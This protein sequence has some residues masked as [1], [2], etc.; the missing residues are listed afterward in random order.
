M[1]R[2]ETWSF[3]GQ[4]NP[5][6]HEALCLDGLCNIPDA[7]EI[8]ELLAVQMTA[9]NVQPDALFVSKVGSGNVDGSDKLISC[10][11]KCVQPYNAGTIVTLTAKPA[12]GYSFAG[13][14]GAC[15]AF[16]VNLSCSVPVNA[17]T[18]V[19]ATFAA[20]PKPSGGGGGGG[21]TTTTSFA[22]SVA[23]NNG[24]IITGS[25]AGDKAINCGKDC[26]AKY[27]AGTVVTLTAVPPAGKAFLGWT[28]ACLAAGT[29]LTCTV[30]M[31]AGK[32]A[33]G[34]FAK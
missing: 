7:T 16:G 14:S 19:L 31:N 12:S 9:A 26:G 34:N 29:N 21:G 6:T 15:A 24:G 10:G 2:I 32:T 5:L 8:G 13:W 28:D 33:K 4:Y 1:R 25:P 30:T 18:N 23:T 22:L 27:A 20:I 3:T 17:A 11:S